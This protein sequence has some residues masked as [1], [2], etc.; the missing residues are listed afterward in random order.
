MDTYEIVLAALASLSG[1]AITALV[2]MWIAIERIAQAYIDG[3]ED[4]GEQD[5]GE[6][7]PVDL[8]KRLAHIPGPRTVSR[9]DPPGS[10][11]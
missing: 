1:A 10:H 4:R 7:Q 3:W 9:V 8:I 11:Y 6:T 5:G 2:A